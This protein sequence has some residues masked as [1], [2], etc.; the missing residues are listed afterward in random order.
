MRATH[1]LGIAG[2][3]SRCFGL[4]RLASF[5]LCNITRRPDARCYCCSLDQDSCPRDEDDEYPWKRGCGQE[6]GS[7]ENGSEENEESAGEENG[8]EENPGEEN[9]FA[10]AGGAAFPVLAT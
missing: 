5:A 3:C 2:G 7:E 6:N 4:A 10:R 9:A 1:G 8:S